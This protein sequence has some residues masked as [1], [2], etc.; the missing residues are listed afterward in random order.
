MDNK[1]KGFKDGFLDKLKSFFST[2]M[3]VDRSASKEDI[4]RRL[5][6]SANGL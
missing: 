6:F 3:T 4:L 5:N 1:L 2:Y